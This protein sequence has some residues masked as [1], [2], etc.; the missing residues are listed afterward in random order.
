MNTTTL[1]ILVTLPVAIIL[2]LLVSRFWL[3]G[4]A[5]WLMCL[6]FIFSGYFLSLF[7][8]LCQWTLGEPLLSG[9]LRLAGGFILFSILYLAVGFIVK[10]RYCLRNFRQARRRRKYQH[11][12]SEIDITPRK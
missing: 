4:H 2:V 7:D 9:A 1:I 3:S 5:L 11:Y 8:L 6:M 12:V 10:H